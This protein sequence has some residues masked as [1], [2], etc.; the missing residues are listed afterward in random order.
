MKG[1][2]FNCQFGTLTFSGFENSWYC[3]NELG[4]YSIVLFRNCCICFAE[5]AFDIFVIFKK[6]L[7]DL[8]NICKLYLQTHDFSCA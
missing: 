2:P 4:G 6:N 5:Y 1:I 3:I 7:I 8:Q